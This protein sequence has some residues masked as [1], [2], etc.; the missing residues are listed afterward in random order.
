MDGIISTDGDN[1]II[2]AKNL[3]INTIFHNKTFVHLSREAVINTPLDDKRYGLK[4]VQNMLPESHRD[5]WSS[6]HASKVQ[7]S[8]ICIVP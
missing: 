1:I 7:R 2:G 4:P 6:G 5:I 3:Y 8:V